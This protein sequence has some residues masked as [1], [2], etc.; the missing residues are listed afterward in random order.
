MKKNIKKFKELF[1]AVDLVYLENILRNSGVENPILHHKD[2]DDLSE[3]FTNEFLSIQL[4]FV[5]KYK[6]FGLLFK[7]SISNDNSYSSYIDWNKFMNEVYEIDIK[8]PDNYDLNYLVSTLIHELRHIIDFSDGAKS[9]GLSSFLM[10]IHLRNFNIGLFSDFYYLVYLVLEHELLA[11]NN[12]IYPY[13]KF[14][15]LSKQQSMDIL[16][17]SFIWKS[18]QHLNNFNSLSFIDK[19]KIDDLIE[20]T[21]LFIRVVLHDKLTLIEDKKDLLDFYNIWEQHFKEI[22]KKWN[23][24][25]ISEVDRIYERKMWIFNE[26]IKSTAQ[27]ILNEKWNI[28]LSL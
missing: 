22:S 20:K 15:T 6:I 25:L 26:G 12:Q 3:Y 17:K 28:L 16:K 11:R 24:I 4:P 23:S 14:K 1:E 13:I 5:K 9:S 18:L 8:V 21:N 10:D 2:L 7:I 19:F 27:K